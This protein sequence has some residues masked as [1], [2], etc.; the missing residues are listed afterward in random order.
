MGFKKHS[1][2]A[3]EGINKELKIVLY[4]NIVE[5]QQLVV[6]AY[7]TTDRKTYTGS[8][9]SLSADDIQRN[10]SNNVLTSLQGIVP[11]LQLE[12]KSLGNG[13]SMPDIVIRGAS[14][15]NSSIKPLYIIDGVP[16]DALGLLNPE[17]IASISILK[18]AA[19]ISLYGARATNGVILVSTKQGRKAKNQKATISYSGQ[20]GISTRTGKDYKMVSPKDYY[21]LSWEALRNGADDNPGLLT[22][23]GK[24]YSSSAEYATGELLNTF[25][26]NAYDKDQPVGI[27]GQLDPTARLLWWEDYGRELIKT[28]NRHEHSININDATDRMKYYLSASYL[29]QKGLE[30]GNSGFDRFTVRTNL[31]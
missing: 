12:N 28:G 5:M 18:D 31:S 3:K 6:V 20:F 25:G 26:Y 8:V 22:A 4:P 30:P 2:L 15:I 17:D 14:S 9:A 1:I 29:N 11:G 10:K 13:Q 7:G 27:D 21:E 24:S 19:A 16:G 23:G